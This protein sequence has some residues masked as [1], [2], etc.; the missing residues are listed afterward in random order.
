VE[1]IVLGAHGPW[2]SPGGAT[3]GYIVRHDGFNLW[4]DLGSGT[5]GNLQKHIRVGE[6]GAAFVSHAHPD[7]F[8]ELYQL[9][10][11][12]Y[13]DPESVPGLPLY[14]PP[15]FFDLATRLVSADTRGFMEETFDVRETEPGSDFEIGPFRVA[16]RPMAHLV[17]TLGIRVEADGQVLAY[18]GDT[19]P[20]EQIE[21]IAKDA[22]MLLAEATWQDDDELKWFHL[23]SRQA[24]EHAARAGAGR[25][26]LT[27]MYPRRD[28][29][30][31]R[32]QAAEAYEG[33]IVLASEG[34]RLEV[35]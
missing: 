35:G 14:C 9:S 19:G 24:A 2:P 25:L 30:A 4:A 32:A 16:T 20:T 7:H 15:G 23:S 6:V 17:T 8:V 27:H 29:E 28:R 1:L 10:F 11:A 31:A 33:E 22:G 12:R 13:F 5:L 21:G 18:T 3:S 34:L 26:V